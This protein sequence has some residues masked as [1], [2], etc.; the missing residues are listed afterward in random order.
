MIEQGGVGIIPVPVSLFP[1]ISFSYYYYDYDLTK[2]G[3]GRRFL[4]RISRFS[5]C[6][7]RTPFCLEEEG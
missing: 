3:R 7:F 1:R 4:I 5:F 6:I 2:E